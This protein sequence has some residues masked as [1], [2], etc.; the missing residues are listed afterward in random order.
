MVEGDGWTKTGKDPNYGGGEKFFEFKS[1]WGQN[2][3]QVGKQKKEKES[4]RG[5]SGKVGR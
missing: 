4:K 2:V 1:A 3:P 5:R